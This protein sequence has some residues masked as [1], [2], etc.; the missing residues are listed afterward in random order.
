MNYSFSFYNKS[1]S[2]NFRT[3]STIVFC[4]RGKKAIFVLVMVFVSMKMGGLPVQ[5]RGHHYSLFLYVYACS[6]NRVESKYPVFLINLEV[7][8]KMEKKIVGYCDSIIAQ[9]LIHY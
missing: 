6:G 3:N 7:N 9:G 1:L 2:R 5:L 8:Q 4:V